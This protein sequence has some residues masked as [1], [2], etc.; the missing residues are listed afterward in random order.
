ME[1]RFEIRAGKHSP[2]ELVSIS[3]R[4]WSPDGINVITEGTHTQC[5]RVL[6]ALLNNM[7]A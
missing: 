6:D 3:P 7:K 1:R 4:N 5:Q 2:C